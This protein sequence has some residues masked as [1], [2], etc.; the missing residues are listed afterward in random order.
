MAVLLVAAEAME[1]VPGQ[2]HVVW[3]TSSFESSQDAADPFVILDAQ[4]AMISGFEEPL[5]SFVSERPDHV[6]L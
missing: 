4:A 6:Q 1:V 2:V 3:P 5:Q